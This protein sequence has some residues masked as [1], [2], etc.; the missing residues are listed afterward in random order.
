MLSIYLGF[1]NVRIPRFFWEI[2]KLELHVDVDSRENALH[3]S[4]CYR[5]KLKKK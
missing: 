1:A 4:Y 2:T 5:V 3:I